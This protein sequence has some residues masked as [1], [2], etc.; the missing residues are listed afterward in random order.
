MLTVTQKK[1]AQAIVNIFETGSVLG[2]YGNVTLIQGDTGH[3]TFGR[4]QTTLGS[5]NL[6]L[7]L[8]QYCANAG[9]SFASRI[10]PYLPRLANR[11]LSLDNE[12]HLH[13]LLRATA[14]DSVMRETQ[15][16][17]FDQ[18]YWEPAVRAATRFGIRTPLGLAVAYDSKIHG[19]LGTMVTRTIESVGN[20][21]DIGER[22]WVSA[23]VKVRG[24]WLRNHRRSD[25]RATVYRMDALQR[26]IEL[27]EWGLEL[28]LVVR[29]L[30]ISLAF[31]HSVPPKSFDGPLP[32]SRSLGLQ[33]PLARG[34]DVRL[35][36]L[37]LSA[38][39]ADIK[40]DGV[41][42]KN[43]QKHLK[44]YQTAR[45]LPANGIADP[46]LAVQLAQAA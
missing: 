1:T 18:V 3:L 19:S 14:D 9:A 8:E 30:E 20:L 10:A 7:L 16:A 31:L 38:Q 13:N 45:G 22:E 33:S 24:D 35:L 26:L 21:D 12:A 6:A 5:G 23:Y 25:L 17:F 15:D 28:P 4:S 44:V 2:D 43:S 34:L 42:G 37:G 32:G 29:G 27:D 40:A 39:G 36:Q 41:F 46:A 11:D